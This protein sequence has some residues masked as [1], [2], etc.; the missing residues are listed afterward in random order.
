VRQRSE[1]G[2]VPEDPAGKVIPRGRA[3]ALFARL[4]RQGRRIVFTNGCFDILHA[5]HARYLR[6]AAALG[7]V[8]VVG[9]NSDASVRRLK[10]EGRPVQKG[11]DRA[12]L[13]ASLACV[14][15]VVLFAEDTPAHLIGDVVPHVLVKGGD[16]KRNEIVG[17]DFVR[18]RGGD[19][20]TIRFLRGRSTSSILG[21]IVESGAKR[22]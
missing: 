7:D 19:V 15:Y 4:R 1:R 2:R 13:L 9:L 8:L 10:G 21:R 12:Y 17:A 18:S 20:R 11:P 22:V 16:W 5:G 14:A 6:E 3:A